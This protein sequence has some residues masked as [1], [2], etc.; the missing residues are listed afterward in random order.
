V[1]TRDGFEG[2]FLHPAMD[3]PAFDCGG[4]ALLREITGL[5]DRFP[6]YSPERDML[7]TALLGTSEILKV[8]SEGRMVL[9]ETIKAQAHIGS[10]VAFVGLGQKFRIWEPERFRAHLDEAKDKVRDLRKTLGARTA[11]PE[12]RSHGA[13]E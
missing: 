1:L 3:A 11:A 2:L 9:S 13:R 12:P 4:H 8:D 5:L 7:S 10:E 6:P